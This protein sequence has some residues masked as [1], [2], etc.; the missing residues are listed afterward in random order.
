MSEIRTVTEKWDLTYQH[1]AG[2]IVSEFY[3]RVQEEGRI[4][5]RQC[6]QCGRVL[7]PPRSFCDRCYCDTAEWVNVAS[8]GVVETFTVVYRKFNRLPDPPYAIAYVRLD[9]AD[10]AMLN[11]VRGLDLSDS[12][13]AVAA[14]KPGLRVRVAFAPREQR[15][16][17]VSDFWWEPLHG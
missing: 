2:P 17:S 15:Q 8:E 16:G 5:G 6:P 9:G 13:G 1:S 7:V 12:D 11:Y 3:R 14:L 4:A 10:T